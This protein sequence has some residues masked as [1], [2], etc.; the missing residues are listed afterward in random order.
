MTNQLKYGKNISLSRA[1]KILGLVIALLFFAALSYAIKE[2]GL[3]QAW[4]DPLGTTVVAQN[5]IDYHDIFVLHGKCASFFKRGHK[6]TY[7]VKNKNG[8]VY[9]Y[10]P[11]GTPLLI[12]PLVYIEN[13]LGFKAYANGND[14]KIQKV[15]VMGISFF[16]LLTTYLIANRF[17]SVTWSIF[18]SSLTFFGSLTGPTVGTGL[19]SIDFAVL[20]TSI[21][22]LILLKISA[23]EY[24]SVVYPG[25][26]LGIIF[27]FGFLSRP[28]FSA[29][30]LLSFIFL[31][32]KNQKMLIYSAALSGSLLFLFMTYCYF[33]IGHILPPYYLLSRLSPINSLDAFYGLL[34]SPSRSIFFFTPALLLLPFSYS[35]NNAGKYKALIIT[36]ISII[37]LLFSINLFFPHWDAGW[38][39]GPRILT[40]MS[41]I[42]VVIL[43]ILAGNRA[44]QKGD[45]LF[46]K[47]VAAFLFVGCL[48]DVNGMY[49]KYTLEW[50]AY[51]NSDQ[52]TN[53]VVWSTSY[54][55]FLMNKS[56]LID[57]CYN[58]TRYLGIN[59]DMC[60]NIGE[61]QPGS[62]FYG[63]YSRHFYK[64]FNALLAARNC[65]LKN[66]R[67]T[68]LTPYN[69]ENKGC[70]SS[71][72]GGFKSPAAN[73][74]WTKQGGWLGDW[75]GDNIAIGIVAPYSVVKFIIATYQNKASEIFFPYPSK[76]LREKIA[77]NESGQL[78]MVF[79]NS[80]KIQVHKIVYR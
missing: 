78:L 35:G 72:Y 39:Y 45:Y 31:F 62:K 28:T 41:Y 40:G 18:F 34:F 29:V 38:S 32:F 67:G 9:Y 43:L 48:I 16:I 17:F 56:L 26:V 55:Q 27:F 70:L 4:S 44:K 51:P 60:S 12:T 36:L 21:T 14:L 24:K 6:Y 10:F 52:Y 71:K 65:Y 80:K 1:T 47:I 15:A 69:I 42:G 7:Q 75:P 23:G 68:S 19:W 63:I 20:F 64:Q 59:D 11:I 53:Y 74:N 13:S 61:P 5:I 73:D 2:D 22:I 8:E 46:A 57:K 50:N 58:Q 66:D 25:L 76:F 30:I 33:K 49:N 77:G 3:P 54:P 79:S 37:I